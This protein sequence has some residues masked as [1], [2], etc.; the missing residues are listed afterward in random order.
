MVAVGAIALVGC[1]HLEIGSPAYAPPLP[2]PV[3]GSNGYGQPTQWLTQSDFDVL[4]HLAWPQTQAAMWGTFGP[5]ARV[6]AGAEVYKLASRPDLE[7]WVIYEGTQAT[8]YQV[9]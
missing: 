9:R 5:P 8:G 6:E 3:A 4:Y 1:S 7:V 2:E